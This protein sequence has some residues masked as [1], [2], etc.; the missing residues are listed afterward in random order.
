MA[1]YKIHPGIGIA[2]LGNSDTEFYLAPETPA[3][4]PTECDDGGNEAFGP[5]GAPVLVSQ[6]RDSQGRIKRQAARFQVFVYD[7]ES[8]EGRPLK[9]GDEIEG[10]GN[11]GKLTGIYWRVYLANKKACWYQFDT[12]IGE[13]GYPDGYPRRNAGVA[14]R[15]R[16][17]ID[18][19]PRSVG[20][21]KR[22][23][24][25]DCSGEGN[26]ATTF[27]PPLSP[28]PIRT[29]GDMLL[30]DYQ[31]LIVL[32]GHGCSGSENTGPGEPHTEDYANNDGWYDDTSDGPVMAR[33]VMYSEEVTATRYIDVEYPAWVI[34]GYPRYVPQMLDMVTMDEVLH[35]LA[36]RYFATDTSLY[37]RLGSFDAPDE[38]DFR[39]RAQLRQWRDGGRL[40]W[41]TDYRPLFYRDIWPILYRPDQFRFVC[42][43][44]AQ[45]NYP[46]DQEQRGLFDPTKLS[47]VPGSG[48]AQKILAQQQQ[49]APSVEEKLEFT[50]LAR[51]A[52]TGLRRGRTGGA[53]PYGPL[54]QFLFGLLRLP[55]EENEFK[56]EDRVSS[57]LH[58]LPLM[59]L[60]C[61]DNPLT[62]TAASKFL[63]LTDYML[64]ILKQW[65]DGRFINE[66][67]EGWLR[68]PPYTPYLPY[69]TTPPKAGRALDRGVLTNVLGGRSD[70]DHAQPG[71]LLGAVPL[72][73]RPVDIGF[74]RKRR[75]GKPI[76]HV[77][78]KRVYVQC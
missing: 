14:D 18:P 48:E 78:R 45:S 52:P 63:R 27:P 47:V 59:P 73:G 19:G 21:D 36:L 15:R 37:G 74:R 32:G 2:R 55:G 54:R 42:D 1:T 50:N 33:L 65:A 43:V 30:D 56:I 35:D 22:R 76:R 77:Q 40:T 8:R 75:S 12:T 51:L 70:L 10:G 68:S 9:I 62:N 28:N 53:D 4:L 69:P 25:F 13:H 5:D 7:E 66:I 71:G 29:L 23:A 31:R 57:R 16:L 26:Y 44:L 38:I 58:N 60:L 6:F 17:I 67:D 20:G 46:H 39:N 72:Q 64:F 49:G 3:G 11:R 61:G 24:S 41:N 34:V